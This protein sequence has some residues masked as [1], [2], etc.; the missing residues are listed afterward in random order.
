MNLIISI[1]EESGAADP[2]GQSGGTWTDVEG[3][4]SL[5]ASMITSGG[6]EFF[7][8]QRWSAEVTAVFKLRYIGG[9]TTKDR[10]RYGD[11]IFNILLVNNVD[12]KNELLLLTCKEVL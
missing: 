10:V 12:E 3:M 5:F 9:I 7:T 2:Y 1:Q 11:R 6:R 8:A 4:S